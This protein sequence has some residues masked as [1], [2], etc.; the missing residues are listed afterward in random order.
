MFS[1]NHLKKV[2][3]GK[4]EHAFQQNGPYLLTEEDLQLN[5]SLIRFELFYFSRRQFTLRNSY[6]ISIIRTSKYS[7]GVRV[8]E[9]IEER[10]TD[11]IY[12]KFSNKRPSL[13]AKY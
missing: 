9:I 10:F 3:P 12:R 4:K 8:R 6:K 13:K 7:L 11:M 5:L 2:A 1:R